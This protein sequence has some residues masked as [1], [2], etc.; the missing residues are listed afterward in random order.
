MFF[1][2]LFCFVGIL[3]RKAEVVRE[4]NTAGRIAI[5]H[6]F[7]FHSIYSIFEMASETSESDHLSYLFFPLAL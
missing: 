5:L 6:S 4:N 3:S 7:L 2:Y 1:A